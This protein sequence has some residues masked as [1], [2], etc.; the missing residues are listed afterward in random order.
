MTTPPTLTLYQWYTIRHGPH[1]IMQQLLDAE[2]PDGA[3]EL[4]HQRIAECAYT[5]N[6]QA[7][8]QH[9]ID[10]REKELGLTPMQGQPTMTTLPTND[11][12][13]A[14]AIE[15]LYQD[16]K[17]GTPEQRELSVSTY[18][19]IMRKELDEAM[20]AMV[21]GDADH[22]MIELLQVVAV[23][24]AAMEQHGVVERPDVDRKVF[25]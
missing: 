22:A 24:V 1:L 20:D 14:I 25:Y 15:R 9:I 8:I 18:L 3:E 12:L 17:Y 16:R 7:T 21:E 2:D 10:T 19:L 6:L 11:I 23:G 13:F 5:Q 4:E